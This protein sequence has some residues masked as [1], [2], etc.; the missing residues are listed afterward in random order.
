MFR[1]LQNLT[2]VLLLWTSSALAASSHLAKQMADVEKIRGLKFKHDVTV[3]TIDRAEIPERLRA[4]MR[5]SLPY[6]VDD[7]IAILRDLQLVDGST[8]D[9]TNKLLDLYEAQVLAYYDPATHTYY[10]IKQ[11]PDA[12]KSLGVGDVLTESV[13][14]HELTHALQDQYFDIGRKDDALRND[15]DAQLAYH[16]LIEGEASLVMMAWT[17]DQAGRSIDDAVKSDLLLNALSS[18]AAADMTV[19]KSAPRYFVESLKF[20]YLD[21]LRFCIAAYKRGGWAELNRVHA[22]PPRTTREVLF[23]DEYFARTFAPRP[24]TELDPPNALTVEHLGEFHWAFLAGAASARGWVD[25]RVTVTCDHQ[26]IA[27][28]TWESPAR[29]QAFRDAYVRFLRDRG[30]EPRAELD[31]AKLRVT[32]EAQP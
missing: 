29:A 16:S 13:A 26:V 30:L 11:L 6:P 9:L 21:G 4:E 8:K 28:T 31:G 3:K 15:W 19:D 24:Y 10:E 20:P 23:P 7:Y 27:E 5:R 25:D 18:G 17:L 12:A 22:H 1:R 14:I 32:Y 2:I